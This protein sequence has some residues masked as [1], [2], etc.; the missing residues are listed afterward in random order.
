MRTPS[1]SIPFEGVDFR[2][3]VV[4]QGYKGLIGCEGMPSADDANN[5]PCTAIEAYNLLNFAVLDSETIITLGIFCYILELDGS[6]VVRP[7][8]LIQMLDRVRE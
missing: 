6:T 3:L 1:G 2:R 5:V 8:W 4:E 7:A